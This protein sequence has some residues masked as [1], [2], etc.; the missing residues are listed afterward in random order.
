M[1]R[2]SFVNRGVMLLTIT[3]G[4]LLILACLAPFLNTFRFPILSLISLGLPLIIL[5]YLLCLAYLLISDRKKFIPAL[6]PLVLVLVVHGS[7]I[8]MHPQDHVWPEEDLKVMSFNTRAFNKYD[9]IDNKSTSE[10][11]LDFISE[12]DPDIACFQEFGYAESKN[13]NQYPYK[14]I[15]YPIGEAPRVVLAIFSKYPIVS[16]GT[17]IFENSVNNAIYADVIYKKDTVRVYSF[18]LESLR[19]NPSAEGILQEAS[20]N[21][22]QRIGRSFMKQEEQVK[23]IRA[24]AAQVDY[25]L[26]FCGDLNNSP[27]SNIYNQ[28]KGDMEDSFRKAGSGFGSTYNLLF[29]PLRIDYILADEVFTFTAHRTYKVQLSDHKPIMATLKYNPDH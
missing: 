7:I 23:K 27:F 18:H 11:I 29:L 24:H 26:I 21:K 15:D 5:A 13:L 8:R 2:I 25:P 20:N 28:L 1:A 17:L 9:W 16:K 10:N 4:L 19:L 3:L 22:F 6:F 12:E 14:F